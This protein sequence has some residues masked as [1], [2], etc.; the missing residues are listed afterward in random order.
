VKVTVV[1]TGGTVNKRYDPIL[2]KLVVP[3]D[4]YAVERIL[5]RF[6]SNVEFEISG[7]I[8]KD[9]LNMDDLDRR[10]IYNAV[11]SAKS[12]RV[13]IVHGTDTMIETARFIQELGT[14]KCVVL[15]GSMKPYIIDPGEACAN[16][17]TALAKVMYGFEAGC[18]IA[19]H[20]FA[21]SWNRLLKD[22]KEGRFRLKEDI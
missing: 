7:L 6:Y 4:N 16:F 17:A 1:N 22:K 20:S 21:L 5:E 12:D 9:S 14:E 10:K 18:F 2:G 11:E 8:Y 3:K 13:I 15:T 19:M